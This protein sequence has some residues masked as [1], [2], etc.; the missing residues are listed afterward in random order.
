[1]NLLIKLL[2]VSFLVSAA[3]VV[4]WPNIEQKRPPSPQLTEEDPLLKPSPI[5]ENYKSRSSSIK[6]L[7][8]KASSVNS[9][10]KSSGIYRWVDENGRVHFSDQASHEDA[11]SFTPKKLG[12]LDVSDDIK[13]RIAVDEYQLSKTKAELIADSSYSQAS[14]TG[15][16]PEVDNFQFSNVSAGQKHGYVLMSG[17]ISR[18]FRCKQLEVTAYASSDKGG[19]VR[20][21]DIVS[22][23]GSGSTLYEIKVGHWW[24]GKGRRPQWN[25]G[26]VSAVCLD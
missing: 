17:R 4:F 1:M 11:V 18:G 23:R 3:V 21:H 9:V 24:K 26:S 22:S 8:Q 10:T 16:K 6:A 25:A 5:I 20:G 15:T 13:Q 2:F 12:V 14:R 7:R 19:F